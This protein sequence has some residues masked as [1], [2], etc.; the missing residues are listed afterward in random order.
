MSSGKIL[1][2]CFASIG[3]YLDTPKVEKFKNQQ[4]AYRLTF[5]RLTLAQVCLL[6]NRFIYVGTIANLFGY[7]GA[8]LF[9]N[10]PTSIK[11]TSFPGSLSYRRRVGENPGNKFATKE[12]TSPSIFK[13]LDFILALSFPC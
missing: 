8:V 5:P 11:T 2:T 10:L 3:K 1:L 7:F 9:N 4:P 12:A 13:N 6:A